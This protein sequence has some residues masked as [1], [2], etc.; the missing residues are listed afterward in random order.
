MKKKYL[1]LLI[2]PV[3]IGIVILIVLF[4]KK[5]AN[6][7]K[8]FYID[9]RYYNSSRIVEIDK[10]VLLEKEN[11]KENFLLFIYQ[12]MCFASDRFNIILYD[13]VKKHNISFLKIQFS[14]IEETE[15][16]ACI[17]YYPSISIYKEGKV[18]AYLDA[19]EDEDTKYYKSVNEFKTWL[20]QYIYIKK[21]V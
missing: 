15:L 6:T 3:V 21:E 19:N 10:K 20:E 2:I 8:L 7:H 18:V 16:E 4:L 1:L 9:N 5:D 12:P 11:N 14:E 17:K 13:F